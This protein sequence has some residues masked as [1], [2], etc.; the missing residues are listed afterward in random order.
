MLMRQLLLTNL[1]KGTNLVLMDAYN[2]NP[3]SMQA[4]ITNFDNLKADKKMVIL[5]DMFE[6][7][8]EG[9]LEHEAIGKL[10]KNCQFETILLAGPMMQNALVY[11]PKAYYFPDKFGLHVWLQEHK[12]SETHILIKGSRGM[13]L[14]SCLAIL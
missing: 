14:E 11:L 10:L 12:T 13:G 1:I 3:S 9:P 7:G 8:E 2:A 5:G 6:L 4:A